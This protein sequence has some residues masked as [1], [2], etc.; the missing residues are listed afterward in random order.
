MKYLSEFD[1]AQCGGHDRRYAASLEYL[2]PLLEADPKNSDMAG[3]AACGHVYAGEALE[4]LGDEPNALG[5]YGKAAKLFQSPLLSGKPSGHSQTA[6]ALAKVAGAQAKLGRNTEA[7]ETYL[8]ALELVQPAPGAKPADAMAAYA[9]IDIFA[10]LGDLAA[11]RA[12]QDACRWY[13]K[14]KDMW[15]QL[16]VRN[17]VAPNGFKVTDFGVVA[18]KATKCD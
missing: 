4:Q 18:A 6:A 14:S 3:L 13:R 2:E 11:Q 1:P 17:T 10:G 12:G 15:M 7:R 8:K 16:P 5:E 9:L